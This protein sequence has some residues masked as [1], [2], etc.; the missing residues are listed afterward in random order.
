MSRIA[1]VLVVEDEPMFQ[2]LTKA[3]L[4]IGNHQVEVAPDAFK[5]L[6]LLGQSRFDCILVDYHL[7]EMDGYAFARLVR[8]TTRERS[9]TPLLVAVTGD[10]DGLALRRGSDTIFHAILSKPVSAKMLLQI[11]ETAMEPREGG[12]VLFAARALVEN[13]VDSA[14][15]AAS[16]AFWR[17]AG[18]KDRPRVIAWPEPAAEQARALALCFDFAP[19]DEAELVVLLDGEACDRMPIELGHHV[20][21]LPVV[22]VNKVLSPLVDCE[23]SL[24][25]R[26]C[27]SRLADLLAETARRNRAVPSELLLSRD[28]IDRIATFLHVRGRTWPVAPELLAFL[29]E[30]DLPQDSVGPLVAQ[31]LLQL[32][33]PSEEEGR[34]VPEA[35]TPE[36]PDRDPASAEMR[37]PSS[38]T[39]FLLPSPTPSP[40]APATEVADMSF[41]APRAALSILPTKGARDGSVRDTP[42][43]PARLLIVEP[44]ELL[45][46]IL[47]SILRGAQHEV[48]LAR[49]PAEA[50]VALGAARFDVIVAAVELVRDERQLKDAI[51]GADE[52]ATLI[53][54]VAPGSQGDLGSGYASAETIERPIK[55]MPLLACV[56]RVLAA[57]RTSPLFDAGVFDELAREVGPQT[58][59]HLGTK[60][61]E[62][63][64]QSAA[65]DADLTRAGWQH[66]AHNLKAAG[67]LGFTRLSKACAELEQSCKQGDDI[68]P[69]I[70]RVVAVRSASLLMLESRHRQRAAG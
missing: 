58:A 2:D 38:V 37:P 16:R 8:N 50:V 66:E 48:I 33:A 19:A 10:R 42:A 36:V 34:E 68:Q 52:P 55:P 51:E 61:R 5:A 65:R 47:S 54:T 1:R 49:S 25:D 32:A 11:V 43:C 12:D 70:A 45:G 28:P 22:S 39:P 56:S 15:I 13:P 17:A 24:L 31:R 30:H 69:G 46:D 41:P 6:Q 4:S 57:S 14:A 7:P 18:L 23:F 40:D 3:I 53:L 27:W 44:G 9:E 64:E 60:L 59:L 21:L 35:G 20:L 67:T 62:R 63:L 26:L 29:P